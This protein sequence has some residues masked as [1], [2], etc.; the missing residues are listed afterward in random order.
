MIDTILFDFDGTV[1]DTNHLIFASWQHVFRKLDGRERPESEI[2]A[3]FGAPMR[4]TVKNFYPDGDIDEIL[5]IYRKYH[6]DNFKEK[7]WLFPGIREL[8]QTLRERNCPMGIVTNRQR[9][10]TELGL[11]N[12]G[13]KEFF[14]SVVCEG[15]AERNK[16]FPEPVWLGLKELGSSKERAILV[17]DSQNDIICGNNAGVITVRVAWAVATDEEHKNNVEVPDY[18]IDHPAD[19]ID[20]LDSINNNADRRWEQN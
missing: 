9:V 8:L 10:S 4:D 12:C 1:I 7:T 20:L 11:N 17:G 5:D 16:P 14:D 3:T 13:I 2:S 19:L 6:H 15:D 18:T